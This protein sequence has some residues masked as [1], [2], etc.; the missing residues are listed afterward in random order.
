MGKF[1]VIVSETAIKD[2]ARHKT[3]HRSIK[4]KLFLKSWKSILTQAQDNPN[5]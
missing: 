3:N 5:S 1:R 4:L 2:I